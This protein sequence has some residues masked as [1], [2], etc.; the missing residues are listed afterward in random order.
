MALTSTLAAGPLTSSKTLK[1]KGGVD[2]ANAQ[3]ASRLAWF[4]D[5]WAE[6][7]PEGLTQAQEYQWL[8][9]QAHQKMIDYVV[10]ESRRNRARMLRDADEDSIEAQAEEE[11]RL[12]ASTP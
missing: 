5:G 1:G 4:I 10:A 7:M 6:P 9:D 12:E 3:I 11:T 2:L 8:L